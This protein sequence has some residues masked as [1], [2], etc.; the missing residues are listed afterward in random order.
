MRLWKVDSGEC[1]RILNGHTNWIYSVVFS[2]EGDVVASGSLDNTVRLWDVMTGDCLQTLSHAD[3]VLS[4]VYGCDGKRIATGSKDRTVRIRDV[5]T[6]KCCTVLEGHTHWVREV[7]YSSQGDQLASASDDRTI[8]LWNVQTKVC[9]LAL[10]G[11]TD[12]VHRVAYSANGKLLAS[13]SLDKTVRLWDVSSGECRAVVE[14]F[15]AEVNCVS[16]STSSNLNYLVTGCQDGS[17]LKWQVLE[18]DQC[19]L[20]LQWSASNGALTMTGTSIQGARG[21]TALNKQLLRQRG[22]IGEPERLLR[23]TGKKITMVPVVS[24]LKET[25]EGT[26]EASS[27]VANPPMDHPEQPNQHVEHPLDSAKI[28]EV[29]KGLTYLLDQ[30]HPQQ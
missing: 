27:P 10:T 23:E 18:E 26:A 16:W 29:I 3:F 9:S 20:Q 14:Y 22:A 5:D 2:P 15:P 12:Q 28:K 4:V 13:S 21:L 19:R 8:R 1:Q 6:G 24:K 7:V 17:V 11:H 30:P 25:S